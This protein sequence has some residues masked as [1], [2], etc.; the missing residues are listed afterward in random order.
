MFP[1][2]GTTTPRFG[3]QQE[4][5]PMA[6]SLHDLSVNSYL[7]ILGGVTAWLEQG[8][9][10]CREKGI[11]PAEIAETRLH[12]DMNMF[13]FQVQAITHHSI[14][15]LRAVQEGSYIAQ[16]Q[17]PSVSYG[18]LQKMI[19]DAQ[20]ELRQ[21]TPGELDAREGGEVIFRFRDFAI[22]FT[23][24]NFLL[25]FALPNFYF[26][27]TTAYDILRMKGVPLGKID[28]LGQM[29]IKA[30]RQHDLA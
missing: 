14:G 18:E 15:A 25:S 30:D 3:R 29:R 27:A 7:Q 8:L 21:I 17:I 26:H 22:P 4:D 12:P 1:M 11:D 20:E 28:F 5:L 23:T 9:T 16:P 10:H 13:D 24:E 2:V 19:L 6:I